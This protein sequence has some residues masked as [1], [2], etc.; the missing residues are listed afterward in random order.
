MSIDQIKL[1]HK[2]EK[3]M[4]KTSAGQSPIR[5]FRAENILDLQTNLRD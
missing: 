2:N 1:K 5:L 4:M 3:Q